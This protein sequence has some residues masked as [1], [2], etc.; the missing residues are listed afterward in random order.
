MKTREWLKV[1]KEAGR[2]CSEPQR[3][4]SSWSPSGG[5]T[6]ASR[7]MGCGGDTTRRTLLVSSDGRP[8]KFSLTGTI[9]SGRT[10]MV[11]CQYRRQAFYSLLS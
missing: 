11:L 4:Q 7:N 2:G 1:N 6:Q 9:C 3:I 10:L 8:A 5:Y